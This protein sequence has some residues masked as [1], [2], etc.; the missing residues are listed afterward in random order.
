MSLNLSPKKDLQVE[1]NNRSTL[2]K[3]AQEE[4]LAN[5]IKAQESYNEQVV[6]C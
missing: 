4:D 2:E 1:Q 6:K 3:S 5:G